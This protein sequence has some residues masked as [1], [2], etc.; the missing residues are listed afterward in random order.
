MTQMSRR[1]AG[2]CSVK[3]SNF[4]SDDQELGS[5]TYRPFVSCSAA[6][7]PSALLQNAFQGPPFVD[8]N[9]MRF[10]SGVQMG[11]A[12]FASDRKSTRLNSSHITISYAV[13][14]LK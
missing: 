11:I 4:P 12:L 2:G 14:C 3:S 5:V 1:V 9:A 7:E 8:R 6:P 13:F 10:P